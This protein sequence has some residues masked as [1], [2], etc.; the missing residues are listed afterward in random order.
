AYGGFSGS[1]PVGLDAR[2]GNYSLTATVQ[3]EEFGGSFEV[4]EYVKPEYRVSVTPDRAVAVQ[5]EKG[6]FVVKGEYLFGGPVA[7]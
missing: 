7:G 5:G 3:G 2:L 6:R 1:F 4:Q